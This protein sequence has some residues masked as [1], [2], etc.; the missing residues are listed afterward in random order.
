MS[1]LHEIVSSDH[2]RPLCFSL[3]IEKI[4]VCSNVDIIE[5]D[6]IRM[7]SDWAACSQS[8]IDNYT[9]R[10]DYLLQTSYMLYFKL[11]HNRLSE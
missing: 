7:V 3:A 2:Y 6:S 8:D 10:L 5:A 9:H 4:K 11:W 1:V